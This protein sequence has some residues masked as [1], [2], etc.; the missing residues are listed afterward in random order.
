MGIARIH[1]DSE[2]RG[3]LLSGWL[4][5]SNWRRPHGSLSH[6][7]PGARLDD[8]NTVARNHS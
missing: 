7:P 1:R 6:K 2:E 4:C 3:S 5:H 8:L